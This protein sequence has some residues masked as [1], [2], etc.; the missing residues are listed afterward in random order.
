MNKGIGV[1]EIVRMFVVVAQDIGAVVLIADTILVSI[2]RIES[3][4]DIPVVRRQ[5]LDTVLDGHIVDCE[6]LRLR[7]AALADIASFH[8]VEI[9]IVDTVGNRVVKF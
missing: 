1:L 2:G 5:V 3:E 9:R 4:H 8:R 6:H 7:E